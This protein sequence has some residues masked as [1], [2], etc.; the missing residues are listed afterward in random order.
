MSASTSTRLHDRLGAHV[1]TL[2]G[3]AGVSFAVWAPAARSVR[4]VGDFNR[5]DGTSCELTRLTGSGV[6]ERFVAGAAAGDRYR[7][8]ITTGTGEV[9]EKADPMAFQAETPPATASVIHR[10]SHRWSD[11]GWIERRARTDA[12]AEPVS[13][14]EVHLGSWRRDPLD[15]SR[16]LTYRE[17]AP[18]LAAYVTDMGF[19]HVELLPVMA[20]PFAGS[21]GYQ[22]TS[23]FAPSPRWGD[24]DDFRAFVDHLHGKGIGVIVDW[25]PA[26]FPGDAWA[27]ARFDGTALYE[28]GDPGRRD[29][30]D[31]GT[32]VFDYGRPEVRD[33]LRSNAVFWVDRYHADGIRVDAVASMLYLDYSRP[34]GGWAPNRLG[35]REDLDAVELL[36]ELNTDLH[37]EAPGVLSVAEESTA[38]PGVTR[39]TS[40]GG[41]GFDLK[42]DLGW[43]HDTLAYFAHDPVHRR[44]HHHRL[45][46]SMAYAW[47]ENFLLPLSH[48]EVVHGKGSLVGKMPGDRFQRFANLRALYGLMWAHPGKQLLFM[49]GELAQEREWSHDRA[50]DW[51]VLEDPDHAGVQALVRDL[52]SCYRHRPALWAADFDP[53]GFTWLVA[54][55]AD[56]NV[57]AFLR[58]AAGTGAGGA[59]AAV[60]ACAANLS[61]IP[62]P[63]YRLGLPTAGDWRLVLDTDDARYGGRG[64]AAAQQ[65]V[66]PE[67]VAWHGQPWSVPVDLPALSVLW[68]EPAR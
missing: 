24:P 55:D 48:D 53:A 41:L 13:I 7:F 68:F 66:T 52:N 59:T 67:D 44:N 60:L 49:G 65:V 12:R 32:L 22:V 23:Y 56:A 62:R 50:L 15:G 5:W 42:W 31:W 43:M 27:L 6:W 8:E 37:A 51:H 20:H 10:S 2:D 30:P 16:E 18:E 21:W 45:T 11:H 34:P 26:H 57:I 47:S 9:L 29:H 38:W 33:F 39:P 19:T 4:V 14:Y 28:H 63:G 1:L 54:D 17:L 64:T 58:H 25:V 36:E 40:A 61:G 46:F 3:T 35:G